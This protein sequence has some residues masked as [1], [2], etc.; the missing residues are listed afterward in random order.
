M[1]WRTVVRVLA[2]I[3]VAVAAVLAAPVV[4]LS[5]DE[6]A[7]PPSSAAPPLPAGVTVANDELRCGSGGCFHELTLTGPPE[8]SPADLAASVG[9]P[10]ETCR[11]RSLLDRRQVCTGVDVF[12][13][14]VVLHVRYDRSSVL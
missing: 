8:D 9:P 4:S 10:G 6:A 12:G 1:S 7:V 11:A 5:L 2:G 14:R 3:G 13:T